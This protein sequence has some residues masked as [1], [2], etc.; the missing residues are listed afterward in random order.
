MQPAMN[1]RSRKQNRAGSIARSGEPTDSP[2]RAM[3]VVPFRF[4]IDKTQAHLRRYY[5]IVRP[6]KEKIMSFLL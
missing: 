3:L 6:Y 1:M 4:F 2:D 5:W